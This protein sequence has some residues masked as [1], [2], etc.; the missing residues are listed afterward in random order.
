MSTPIQ[1]D[2]VYKLPSVADPASPPDG[3]LL[4]YTYSWF[5]QEKMEGCSRIMMLA[6]ADGRD[7]EFHQGK[8]D[9]VP[10]FAPNGNN[11]GF[12][13]LDEEGRRQ[14]WVMGVAGEK[15]GV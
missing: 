1:P 9:S 12:L 8:S 3:S 10:K 13:R 4:A 6:V 7:Q 15:Q 11:L 5:D 2:I 14:L